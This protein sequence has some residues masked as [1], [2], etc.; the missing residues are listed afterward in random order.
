MIIDLST[1][2]GYDLASSIRGPDF[3]EPISDTLK[4]IFT[5]RIRY[6]SGATE[7]GGIVRKKPVREKGSLV[8][9]DLME[10]SSDAS[11]EEFVAMTHYLRHVREG[12]AA[13]LTLG[14]K[15]DPALIALSDLAIS[16]TDFVYAAWSD[17]ICE[18]SGKRERLT[19]SMYQRWSRLVEAET[20]EEHG[21]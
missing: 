15:R 9:A 4:D 12:I 5:S 21:S 3:S 2:L 11:K 16:M 14:G 18:D 20:K 19:S 10:W 7:N 17:P 13:L 6:K 8:I 1:Q